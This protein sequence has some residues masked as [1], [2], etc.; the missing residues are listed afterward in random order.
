MILLEFK[1][2]K[3]FTPDGGKIIKAVKGS[4]HLCR[5][6]FADKL[7]DDKFAFIVKDKYAAPTVKGEA[8]VEYKTKQIRA[9]K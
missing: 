4:R 8:K 9:S 5:A 2:D 7:V 1:K 6:D 3:N